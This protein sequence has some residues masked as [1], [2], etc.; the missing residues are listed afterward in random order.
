LGSTILSEY[1]KFARQSGIDVIAFTAHTKIPP[2]EVDRMYKGENLDEV[3]FNL[4]QIAYQGGCH[5]I[6]LEGERLQNERVRR[7][8]LKK[9]VTG[10]RIDPSDKGTQNRVT[11]LGDLGKVKQHVDYVVVSSRYVSDPRSLGAYFSALL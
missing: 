11:T 6:V 7:L 2:E 3:I 9:L 8:P 5:A 4:G 10:I 1:V